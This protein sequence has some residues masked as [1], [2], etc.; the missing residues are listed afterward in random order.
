[1]SESEIKFH[2]FQPLKEFLNYFKITS[3]TLNILENIKKLQ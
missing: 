3:A 1:M 2:V